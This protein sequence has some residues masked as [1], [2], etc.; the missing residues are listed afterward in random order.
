MHRMTRRLEGTEVKAPFA[1]EEFVF[2]RDRLRMET[3][4]GARFM[5]LCSGD[6]KEQLFRVQKVIGGHHREDFTGIEVADLA[7]NVALRGA[8]ERVLPATF[9]LVDSTW[10]YKGYSVM[11]PERP[12]L[13]AGAVWRESCIFCH[14]TEPLL[15]TL[16]GALAGPGTP[17][18]Q[19]EQVDPLLPPDRRVTLQVTDPVGLRDAVAAEMHTLGAGVVD[20]KL[21][22]LLPLAVAAT[23][24]RFDERHL[25]EVGI[26]CESCHGGAA[27]HVARSSVRPSFA[28][29]SPLFAVREKQTPAMEVNR[30]CARCH[31]VLF[32]RY[33]WTWE[34]G[35]RHEAPG[36]SSINS[37]EA[38]DFLLGGCAGELSCVACHSPHAPDN[39]ARMQALEGVAGN[40]VCLGCH[41]RYAGD[42]AIK[43]HTH[44]DPAG[45]GALCMSCHMPKKNMS[46]DHRLTRYHRIG[47]PNDPVR[48]ERDRPIECALC[49]SDRSVRQLADTIDAW[50]GKPGKGLDRGAL[51]RLY[52]G[53]DVLPLPATVER[54]KPHEQATA[55]GVLA[56]AK[57]RIDGPT[58]ALEAQQ[59]THAIPIVRY[60]AA[61][62]LE[63]ALGQKSL[64]G[65]DLFSDDAT[66][67]GAAL[68]I[69]GAA[70]VPIP[71]A[72]PTLPQPL[73]GAE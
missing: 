4:D 40:T 38:R 41:Q 32:S 17:P 72:A 69:L 6:G 47:S 18:Y 66:I 39:A 29:R 19:G 53:L 37:G 10:R 8:R 35:K 65:I 1:G 11:T 68:R 42:A 12:A 58:E 44:H 7:S 49:H 5:R 70:G 60:Y 71:I 62:A 14:N 21:A 30:V 20:V 33:P 52:G 73:D 2:K 34:G 26:G 59:L 43:A 16:L 22:A 51:V 57:G 48:V 15:S 56:A 50:W 55:L 23:R 54:G 3:H 45:A 63:R 25:V 31:Q 67:Q 13:K 27:E 61:L 28:L 46:L 64:R 36:G 24:N 9:Q